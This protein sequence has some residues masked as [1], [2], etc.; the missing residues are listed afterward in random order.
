MVSEPRTRC[1]LSDCFN[2]LT[3]RDLTRL[4]MRSFSR[5]LSECAKLALI[6]LLTQ[7][8]RLHLI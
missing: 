8:L 4:T 5:R 1:S 7:R 3:S 2:T 6:R